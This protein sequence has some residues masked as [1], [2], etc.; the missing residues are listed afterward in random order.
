MG[1][2][3]ALRLLQIL[4]ERGH[5]NRLT[6]MVMIAPAPDFTEKLMWPKFSEIQKQE[7]LEKGFIFL[8]SAY[9]EH[10]KITRAL[11]EDGKH[12]A[13]MNKITELPCPLHILQGTKDEDATHPCARDDGL[14]RWC[15]H[16]N[17]H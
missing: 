16:F 3:I 4:N 1:G 11:I 5:E 8:P 7:I 15:D 13:V 10:Y 2:W 14:F 17:T 6:G 9:G 12:N